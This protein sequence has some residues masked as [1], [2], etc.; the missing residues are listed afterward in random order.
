MY[1]LFILLGIFLNIP[2]IAMNRQLEKNQTTTISISLHAYSVPQISTLQLAHLSKIY[3][4]V[5]QIPVSVLLVKGCTLTP[6]PLDTHIPLVSTSSMP[7]RNATV[8]FSQWPN[9]TQSVAHRASN[10]SGMSTDRLATMNPQ[11]LN[12]SKECFGPSLVNQREAVRKIALDS[13]LTHHLGMQALEVRKQM[14]QQEIKEVIGLLKDSVKPVLSPNDFSKNAA[15]ATES[16]YELPTLTLSVPELNDLLKETIGEIQNLTGGDKNHTQPLFLPAGINDPKVQKQLNQYVASFEKNA[17]GWLNNE[18][19]FTITCA[20]QADRFLRR[21]HEELNYNPSKMYDTQS[22]TFLKPENKPANQIEHKLITSHPT[23]SSYHTIERLLKAGNFQEA[24]KHCLQLERG[25]DS[26]CIEA[27]YQKHFY[28]KYTTEGIE[29]RFNNNPFYLEKKQELA[30]DINTHQRLPVPHEFNQFLAQTE[31]AYQANKAALGVTKTNPILDNMLYKLAEVPNNSKDLA[32]FMNSYGLSSDNSDPLKREAYHQLHSCGILKIFNTNAE[33]LNDIPSEIGLSQYLNER[34]LLNNVIAHSVIN[35]TDMQLVKNTADYIKMAMKNI[36]EAAQYRTLAHASAQAVFNSASN[37]LI[38]SLANYATPLANVHHQQLQKAAVKLIAKN[39]SIIKNSNSQNPEILERVSAIQKLDAAYRAMERGD[40]RAEFYLEKALTPAVNSE[41]LKIDYDSQMAHFAGIN[42][43]QIVAHVQTQKNLTEV[44]LKNGA[45]YELKQYQIPSSIKEFLISKGLD[46]RKF[47]HCYGHQVQQAIHLDIL[48]QVV[49]QKDLSGLA[50]FDQS[51]VCKLR[52]L[53]TKVTDLSRQHNALGNIEQSGMLSSFCWQLMHHIENTGKYT[54]DT[55]RAVGE[56][57]VQG[58]QNF[59]YTVTH[60]QEAIEGFVNLG[61]TALKAVQVHQHLNDISL[62]KPHSQ[63]LKLEAQ[64]RE[65][66]KEA[67]FTELGG[68]IAHRLQNGTWQDNIRDATALVVENCLIGEVLPAAGNT[69]TRVGNLVEETGVNTKAVAERLAHKLKV[70]VTSVTTVEGI[71]V[72]VIAQANEIAALKQT[73]H[74]GNIANTNPV[75][76]TINKI[77]KSI[78]LTI[79]NLNS[80]K[81]I[82]ER[83]SKLPNQ[84]WKKI[85]PTQ[86]FWNHHSLIPKSFEI[87]VE[88]QKF[89]VHPNATEHMMELTSPSQ[90]LRDDILATPFNLP[91][92][93]TLLAHEMLLTDFYGAIKMAISSGNI[94]QTENLVLNGWEIGI[95]L[96]RSPGGHPVIV[97]AFKKIL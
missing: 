37:K 47:E 51:Q 52:D 12:V 68:R 83:L 69:V 17:I 11:S 13:L 9:Q 73:Q 15:S 75:A 87:E 29:K 38:S 45:Q 2:T 71:E 93:Q 67:G 66:C 59:V 18:R 24:R 58:G 30:Q 48:E 81:I 91:A 10:Y 78:P 27:V 76:K 53:A 64:F 60:P 50:L 79:E 39:I 94:Y 62:L 89:W 5:S 36:P 42:Q 57:I 33:W 49:K 35:K 6:Q 54:I 88:G 90:V 84:I 20:D 1:L 55:A 23:Y 25:I 74:A 72:K 26:T 85:N 86:E 40:I 32:S 61:K 28:A 77:E 4:G 95:N 7:T 34:E 92:K 56:G 16:W 22:W 41:V 3:E 82:Y 97:H 63:N 46:P 31:K 70:P 21:H 8:D 43:N 80:C 14:V 44:L 19:E 65:A 96:S